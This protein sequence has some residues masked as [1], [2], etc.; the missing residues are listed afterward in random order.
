MAVR[1]K[2]SPSSPMSTQPHG[3]EGGYDWKK[4]AS[5]GNR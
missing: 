1:E 5:I 2:G 3:D 4:A